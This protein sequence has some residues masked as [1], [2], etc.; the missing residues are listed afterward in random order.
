MH[1]NV[2]S[3]AE[4]FIVIWYCLNYLFVG[5]LYDLTFYRS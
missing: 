4:D 3:L 1:S 2:L 5:V